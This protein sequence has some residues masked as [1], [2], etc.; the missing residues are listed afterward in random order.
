MKKIYIILILTSTLFAIVLE[1]CAAEYHCC[2]SDVCI[3]IIFIIY[4]LEDIIK[5]LLKRNLNFY[6]LVTICITIGY[7]ARGM[8]K[9]IINVLGTQFILFIIDK[10]LCGNFS[11][12]KCIFANV[13]MTIYV[14]VFILKRQ[15]WMMVMKK[16]IIIYLIN[17]SFQQK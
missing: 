1:K 2:L 15:S 4:Y 10:V 3:N 11:G 12:V 17:D 5:C 13:Y 8:I 9:L 6:I 16:Y 14:S 7:I